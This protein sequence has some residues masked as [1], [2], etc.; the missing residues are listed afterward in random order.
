MNPTLL[1]FLLVTV[2]FGAG[3]LQAQ[4]ILVVDKLGRPG[5]HFTEIQ[6]AIDV[7]APGDIITVRSVSPAGPAYLGFT[8][9]KS[10]RIV[11]GPDVRV[12]PPSTSYWAMGVENLAPGE[13]VILSGLQEVNTHPFA[14]GLVIQNN[15]GAVHC[16][17]VDII[18]F[19][20]VDNNRQVSFQ[21]CDLIA[22]TVQDSDV[23]LTET[24]GVGYF[25]YNCICAVPALE[26]LSG[27]RATLAGG[28]YVGPPGAQFLGNE[29]AAIVLRQGGRLV[30]TGDSSTTIQG[31]P[32][33]R[34]GAP[35][36]R[37]SGGELVIDPDPTLI[38]TG[39]APEITGPAQ[40]KQVRIP[41]LHTELQGR[42]L[43]TSLETWPGAKVFLFV[44]PFV[45]PFPYSPVTPDIWAG[46]PAQIAMGTVPPNGVRVDS[47]PLPG[48]KPGLAFPLQAVADA[49]GD[50]GDGSG[51]GMGW[52]VERGGVPGS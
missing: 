49:T 19:V 27:S 31:G 5:S 51:A 10:L 18:A 11:G 28:T 50:L 16:E 14:A 35:A 41:Y 26:I 8:V 22:I 29:D 24:A 13:I 42:T 3:N 48:F 2:S 15:Q 6:P 9:D 23:L 36:I 46:R 38:P 12:G 45:P 47:F 17:D 1:R 39:G 40:V 33:F 32:F 4:E 44:S 52:K 7:A 43:V 25:N 21:R 34:T 30:L 37:T 20:F